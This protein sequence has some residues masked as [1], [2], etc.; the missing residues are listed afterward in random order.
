MPQLLAIAQ[1]PAGDGLWLFLVL[2]SFGSIE[3]RASQEAGLCHSTHNGGR[4]RAEF[5]LALPEGVDFPPGET[6]VRVSPG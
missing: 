4:L 2:G 1:Q 5:D 6:T 3:N